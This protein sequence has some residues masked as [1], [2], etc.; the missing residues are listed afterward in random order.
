MFFYLFFLHYIG[1]ANLYDQMNK[2]CNCVS[3]Q[4]KGWQKT[5]QRCCAFFLSLTFIS[6]LKKTSGWLIKYGWINCFLILSQKITLRWQKRKSNSKS[7]Y[8]VKQIECLCSSSWVPCIEFSNVRFIYRENHRSP[9]YYH[10]RY[11]TM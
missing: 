7:T 10:S 11:S 2:W 6:F 9:E 1:K 4:Q 3:V 8:V 5:P